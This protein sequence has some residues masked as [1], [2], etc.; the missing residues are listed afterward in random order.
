MDAILVDEL[1]VIPIFYYVKKYL[2]SPKVK[3]FYPTLLDNHPY[4]YIYLED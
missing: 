4:K 3:G 2:L 1:P